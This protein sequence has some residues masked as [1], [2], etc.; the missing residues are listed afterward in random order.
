MVILQAT[1]KEQ[2]EEKRETPGVKEAEATEIK[3]VPLA[4][5]DNSNVIL[6]LNKLSK[7]TP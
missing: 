1:P 5:A 7:R 2:V 4:L 3:D 6:T